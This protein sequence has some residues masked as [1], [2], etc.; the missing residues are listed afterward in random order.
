MADTEEPVAPRTIPD[1]QMELV[2]GAFSAAWMGSGAW[3][4][5]VRTA[6]FPIW[7]GFLDKHGLTACWEDWYRRENGEEPPE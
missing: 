4:R 1:D 3:N 5:S 2:A 6:H 7:R